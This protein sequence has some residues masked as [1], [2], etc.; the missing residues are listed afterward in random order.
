MKYILKM[1]LVILS[2]YAFAGNVDIN[3]KN[4]NELDSILLQ[5]GEWRDIGPFR[6]G[7]STT[8]TGITGNDQIY[9]MG[10]TGGGLWKTY[11]AGLSWENVSDG[12]F[13]TGSVGAVSVSESNNN[14]VVVGMGESP[15]GE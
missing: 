3:K 2:F 11:D 9:Y 6:G 5:V 12:F 1:L 7:R 10:T 13:A 15:V 8:A 14:I 4:N